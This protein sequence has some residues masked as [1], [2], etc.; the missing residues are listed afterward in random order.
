MR[1]FS[2]I[3]ALWESG[4]Q[5]LLQYMAQ[6]VGRLQ[7]RVEQPLI[8]FI[9]YFFK[10]DVDIIKTAYCIHGP[11]LMRLIFAVLYVS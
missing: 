6:R 11:E 7:N 9:T 3:I 4:C 1:P 10:G 8:G 2:E 5:Q